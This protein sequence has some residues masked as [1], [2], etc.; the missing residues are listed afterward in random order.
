M[1]LE[2]LNL[3]ED[4]YYSK[5]YVSLY[6]KQDETIFEFKYQEN[7]HIFY[8]IAIKRP[9]KKIGDIDTFD[10]YFDLETAYG[11]GGFVINTDDKEFILNAVSQYQK[12]CFDEN[13]IAEFIRFH[14]FNEFPIKYQELFDMNIYDRDVVYVDL[15]LSKEERWNSYSSK[16]RNILRKCE[17]ELIFEQS[18]N[19]NKFVELYEQTMNKNNAG[20]FYYFSKNYYEQLLKNISIDLYAVKKD[21][22]VISSAFFMQSDE[23]VHYHLSANDYNMRQYNANYFILDQ[24]F[25]LAKKNNKKYFY[26]GGGT[27]SLKDD[28]LLKFKQKFSKLTKPFYISGKIYDKE[29][30]D[31]YVKLWEE[32]STNTIKYFLKYRLEIE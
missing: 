20:E 27:T 24:M 30:Y 19:I 29:I 10:G 25:E 28:L 12:K 3:L 23:F 2:K 6:L 15:E 26:L 7:E 31:K 9:I 21:E 13:I 18:T 22:Q 1:S 4:I 5:E 17:K 11:Y 32:Q 8:N 16:T 14:P